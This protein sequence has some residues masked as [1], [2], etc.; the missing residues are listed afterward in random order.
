MSTVLF[1]PTN[2][3]FEAQYIGETTIIKAG[4]KLKCD[5]RRAR[6]ILNVLGPRGLMTLD[7]GDEGETEEAKAT[8]GRRRNHEFKR[9]QV[10]RFNQQN[11]S[12]EQ[13][14]LPYQEPSNQ[15]VLYADETGVPLIQ[16]YRPES[17]SSEKVAALTK[18]LEDKAA[19]VKEKDK[20]VEGLKGEMKELKETMQTFMTMMKEGSQTSPDPVKKIE[21]VKDETEKDPNAIDHIIKEQFAGLSKFK[22]QD[23][24]FKNWDLIP[25]YSENIRDEIH[26][27]W[28]KFF[29]EDFPTDLKVPNKKG[30]KG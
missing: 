25:T 9:T 22:F 2:E 28:K 6:H 3:E 11:Q 8:L 26:K 13:G 20:E 5:D 19:E 18:E 17:D 15:I 23:W 14:K 27:M 1:N 16:P 29:N 21:E 7:Y 24:V 4:E 12:R 10:L 30:K